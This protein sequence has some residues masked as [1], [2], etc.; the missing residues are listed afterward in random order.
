MMKGLKEKIVNSY[1]KG[2]FDYNRKIIEE[3]Q[4]NTFKKK[5]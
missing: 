1:K 5:I 2:K 4:K 3:I